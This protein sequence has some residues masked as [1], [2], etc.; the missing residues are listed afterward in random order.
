MTQ[1]NQPGF[2]ILNA[3]LSAGMM[4]QERN[5]LETD[6]ERKLQQLYKARME[7]PMDAEIK[8]RD[9]MEA[10]GQMTDPD[11]F[12]WKRQGYKGSMMTQDAQGRKAQAMSK[13]DIEK[14]LIQ[15]ATD[16][17]REQERAKAYAAI[18]NGDNQLS[19][20]GGQIGFNMQPDTQDFPQGTAQP[21]AG[22]GFFN[23]GD[24][25][26]TTIPPG[27]AAKER[28]LG[29]LMGNFYR[30][31]DSTYAPE[32]AGKLQG[33]TPEARAAEYQRLMAEGLQNANRPPSGIPAGNGTM[34]TGQVPTS[35]SGPGGAPTPSAMPAPVLS[36]MAHS[37]G[38]GN[39]PT[40]FS[41]LIPKTGKY[42]QMAGLDALTP[43]FVGKMAG[44]EQRIDSAEDIAYARQLATAEKAKKEL[45]EPKYMEQLAQAFKIKADPNATPQQ[46]YEAD[47]FIHLDTQ[48]RIAANPG[49]Y[50]PRMNLGEYGVPMLPQPVTQSAATAPQ[51]PGQTNTPSGAPAAL[52]PGV[53]RK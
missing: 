18:V 5:N 6:N 27:A 52:P 3:I 11:Y 40:P 28:N 20:G 13:G 1:M 14:S 46:K 15:Q 48:R 31:G 22:Q 25:G 34:P 2:G 12:D 33:T 8:R 37:S 49:A 47:M 10:Q 21:S 30:S 24:G 9:M 17:Q 23:F 38:L 29:P 19:P 43:E 45:K 35:W 36:N 4:G 51:P 7:D 32:G 41:D 53:T 50:A 16:M 26:T 39:K 44:A 42:A